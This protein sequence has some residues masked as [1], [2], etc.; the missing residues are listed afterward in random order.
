MKSKEPITDNQQPITNSYH[1][2][3]FVIRSFLLFVIFS[4]QSRHSFAQQQPQYGEY[5]FNQFALNPAYAGSR[6]VLQ[7]SIHWRSQWD[8]M[9][10]DAPK[11]S[12]LSVNGPIKNNKMALGVQL[13]TDEIGPKSSV[14]ALLTYAY[15]VKFNKSSLAAGLRLGGYQYTFNF[16]KINYQVQEPIWANAGSNN[17]QQTVPTADVG[18]FYNTSDMYVG[19]SF[20]QLIGGNALTYFDAT[21]KL[22]TFSKMKPHMYLAS[23]KAFKLAHDLVLNPSI[24]VKKVAG[25]PMNFDLDV[26][27]LIDEHIWIGTVI[28][29]GY[30]I[31][32]LAQV[33]INRHCKV[34][35]SRDR[36]VKWMGGFAAARSNEFL[37]QYDFSTKHSKS[38]SPKY[39]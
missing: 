38:V 16:N 27:I 8:D 20:N 11:T 12:L 2:Y 36:G 29:E 3:K 10:P 35:F 13:I 31:G 5:M 18:V 34:G 22:V 28:R 21:G 4:F 19:L 30:G 37:L 15:R 14:G 25:A 7:T 1:S 6:N 39:L 26:N 9:F 33:L 24:V 23:G 32:V 17:L